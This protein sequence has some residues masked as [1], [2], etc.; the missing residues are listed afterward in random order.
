MS[1]TDEALL[2]AVDLACVRGDRLL[3]EGLSFALAPGT[4]LKV[5]GPNGAGK[6]S[7]LRILAGLLRPEAGSVLWRGRDIAACAGD[8]A[9]DRRYIGHQNGLGLA[10]TAR[11]NLRVAAAL[12]GIDGGAVSLDAVLEAVGLPQTGNIPAVRLS[13]GQRR[14]LALAR[15]LMGQAGVW[16]LDEPLNA[17]DRYGQALVS[18][19]LTDHLMGDGVAVI[20]THQALTL[21]AGVRQQMLTLAV[22]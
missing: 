1:L 2:A 20:S 4:V 10:L 21:P 9:A 14:R 7:L 17:L 19:L 12:Q 18:R 11:E 6:T 22:A 3:F 8:Y 16:I 13:S 15:L 5:E